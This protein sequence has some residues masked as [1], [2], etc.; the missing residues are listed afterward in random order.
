MAPLAR[1]RYGDARALRDALLELGRKRS[2]SPDAAPK[3]A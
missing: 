1:D 3:L 2:A